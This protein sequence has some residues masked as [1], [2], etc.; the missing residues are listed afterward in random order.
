M[1]NANELMIAGL[2][3][4]D[5]TVYLRGLR[6]CLSKISNQRYGSREVWNVSLPVER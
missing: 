5:G 6:P 3:N 2:E 1:T 4:N